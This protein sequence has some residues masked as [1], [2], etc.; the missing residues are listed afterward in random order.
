M[1]SCVH[2]KDITMKATHILL[3]HIKEI[4]IYCTKITS[5]NAKQSALDIGAMVKL[6]AARLTRITCFIAELYCNSAVPL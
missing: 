1:Y 2:E 5:K 6:K 3:C 4:Q